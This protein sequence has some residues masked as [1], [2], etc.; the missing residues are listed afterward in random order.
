MLSFNSKKSLSTAGI[1]EVSANASFLEIPVTKSF[2]SIACHLDLSVTNIWN[3]VFMNIDRRETRNDLTFWQSESVSQL[4]HLRALQ[5]LPAE[6]SAELE[7][8]DPHAPERQTCGVQL[9]QNILNNFVKGRHNF[10]ILLCRLNSMEKKE[11]NRKSGK[12]SGLI[13]TY[14]GWQYP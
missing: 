8:C 5:T 6:Q 9:K 7:H 14:I 2:Y 13:L 10:S 1:S 4:V 12:P 11:G 3:F